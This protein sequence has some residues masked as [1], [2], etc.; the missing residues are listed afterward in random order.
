MQVDSIVE[1]LLEEVHNQGKLNRD[2]DEECRK[3]LDNK[4]EVDCREGGNSEEVVEGQNTPSTKSKAAEEAPT[5]KKTR[6]TAQ[7]SSKAKK[8][9]NA[10]MRSILGR[11]DRMS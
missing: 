3:D 8:K 1:V 10:M 6:W 5:T 7:R 9:S 2:G 11:R 4:K